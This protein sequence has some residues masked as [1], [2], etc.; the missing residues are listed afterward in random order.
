MHSSRDFTV[1][2]SDIVG[3][4]HPWPQ[5]TH[6]I[7]GHITIQSKNLDQLTERTAQQTQMRVLGHDE[8]DDGLLVVHVAATTE[9]A[10]KLY[11]RRWSV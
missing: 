8:A 3:Y 2:Y 4:P 11:E 9:V 10:L 7:L 1:R 6:P 5:D